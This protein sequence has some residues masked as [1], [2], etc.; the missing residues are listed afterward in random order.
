MRWA[1][2]RRV[3]GKNDP[4]G[5]GSNLNPNSLGRDMCELNDIEL[6]ELE[7]LLEAAAGSTAARAPPKKRVPATMTEPFRVV[8]EMVSVESN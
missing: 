8:P 2:Q 4:K 7:E 3:R 1:N 5:S 6:R